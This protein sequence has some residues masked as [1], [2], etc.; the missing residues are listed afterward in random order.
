[1]IRRINLSEP[2]LQYDDSDPEGFRSAML[3]AGPDLG[4]ERTGATLY[5]VP[6]GQAVCPYHYEYGEE[7]WLFVVSGRPSLR[8]P[9]GTERLEPSDLVFFPRGPE[10]AHKVT[11]ET[12][13]AV[14]VL[15]FSDVVLP[16]ATVYPDSDKVGIWT[17]NRDD[18]V[19]VPRDRGV[20]YFHGETR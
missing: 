9:Q 16:T 11:N 18:D 12:D 6:P 8:H 7:E 2:K 20:D 4:A 15:M 14:R 13:E 5:E 3:R 10:G 17:G 1:V 19:L